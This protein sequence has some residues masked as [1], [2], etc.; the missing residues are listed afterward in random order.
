MAPRATAPH[1][2]ALALV[3]IAAMLCGSHAQCPNMCSGHG[4]CGAE[5]VCDCED[6]WSYF[7]DCSGQYCPTGNA[8]SSKAYSADSAH[9][10]EFL[11]IESAVQCLDLNDHER[12]ADDGL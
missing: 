5:N 10:A 4:E 3:L 1:A 12:I 7:P 2:A 8:F 6:A 11:Q 9:T